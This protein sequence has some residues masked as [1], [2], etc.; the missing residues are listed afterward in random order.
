MNIEILTPH[1]WCKFD[2]VSKII[3]PQHCVIKTKRNV[4]RTSLDHLIMTRDGWVEAQYLTQGMLIKSKNRFLKVVSKTIVD[5]YLDL[6]DVTN[7]K[8]ETHSYYTD[9][10]VSHNCNFRGSQNSLISGSDLEKLVVQPIIDTIHS[11]NVYEH[12]VHGDH[13]HQYM[14]TVDVSRGLGGDFST[15][16]VFDITEKPYRQVATY[17]NNRIS[18]ILFPSIIYNTAMYYN[19]A[20]VLV[21]INDIGEQT[22]SILYNEFEYENILTTVKDKNSYTIGF[23]HD[24][25]Y[26]VRTTVKVKSVGVATLET[27]I[28]NDLLVVSD[29]ET[30]CELGTFVPKRGSYEADTG[31]HDDMVMTLVLFAWATTQPYFVELTNRSVRGSLMESFTDLALDELTPFGIIDDEFGGYSG[32]SASDSSSS[33]EFDSWY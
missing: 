24:A 13:P 4:L 22:A 5:E 30:I 27:M 16:S 3:K 9:N 10:I 15:F 23:S 21:E 32:A 14:M 18:P 12:P 25:L 28:H 33:S 1:G 29:N 26:G 7:V 17:R 11:V 20:L 8:N 6:Y 31:A 2:S 19:K